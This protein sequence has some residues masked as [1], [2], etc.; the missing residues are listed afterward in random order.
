MPVCMAGL[1]GWPCNNGSVRCTSGDQHTA[2]SLQVLL[3]RARK[4]RKW[5]PDEDEKLTEWVEARGLGTCDWAGFIRAYKEQLAPHRTSV[6]ACCPLLTKL[7]HRRAAATLSSPVHATAAPGCGACCSHRSNKPSRTPACRRCTLR[8]VSAC[9]RVPQVD[10]K[11]R[12]RNILKKREQLRERMAALEKAQAEA[13][14]AQ[15]EAEQAEMEA[16]EAEQQRNEAGRRDA[17]LSVAETELQSVSQGALHCVDS[18]AGR[19]SDPSEHVID[20]YPPH[21]YR[22]RFGH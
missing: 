14:Q 21:S 15:A 20:G 9:P 19:R 10:A 13:E 12:W 1:G 17:L 16:A 4:R 2:L 7:T 5:T 8:R 11:D 18:S 22:S 3:Q 6:R